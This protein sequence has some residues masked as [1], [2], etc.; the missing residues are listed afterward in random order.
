M[1]YQGLTQQLNELLQIEDWQSRDSSKNGLQVQPAQGEVKRVALAV[2]ANLDTFQQAVAQQAQLL[3]VHHGL[4]WRD[5]PLITDLHYQRLRV[6]IEN[7]VGLYACHLP[8]DAH[9]QIGHNAQIAAKLGLVDL[10]PLDVGWQ[11]NL[12]L[13]THRAE[14]VKSLQIP[15]HQHQHFLPFGSENI[16]HV[17]VL[18]GGGGAHQYINQAYKDGCDL[19]ITGEISHTTVQFAREAKINVLAAGHYWTETFGLLALKEYFDLK[20]GL[21]TVW[22]ESPTDF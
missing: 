22:I 6:L 5:I 15:L 16:N 13:T 17:G 2:D 11:G 4:F 19:Y 8:L 20:T 10:Q 7:G 21:E 9:P 18:S 1:H 3:I 14:V 12:P